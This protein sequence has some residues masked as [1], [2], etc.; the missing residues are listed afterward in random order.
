[1]RMIE[2]KPTTSPSLA[3]LMQ[4]RVS[5]RDV[6]RTG[7]T[8]GV[9][10]LGSSMLG[11]LSS[12]VPLRT[13]SAPELSFTEIEKSV[14]VTHHIAKGYH[15]TALLRWG[16][17]LFSSE[18]T[19]NPT[20]LTPQSQEK[21]IGQNC[22]YTAFMPLP[23]GSSSSTHG[24]L[25][26]NHEYTLSYLMFPPKKKLTQQELLQRVRIEQAAQ[27]FSTVEIK[28]D[29]HG[30]WH[31]IQDSRYNRRVT[32][33]SIVKF[34]G[35][36]AEHPRLHSISCENGC[37][38][39]G[40]F[41][42]CAG[43]VT[44]WGSILTCEENID[45]YFTG[46]KPSN[47]EYHNHKR[48]RIDTNVEYDWH[49][50]D[51][52]FDVSLHP[53]EP[54]HFGWVV[55]YD[56]YNPDSI[57]TKRTAL[58][59][60]KHEGATT[61]L[62]PD[63]RVVVYMGDDEVFQY[64][65]RYVSKDCYQHN[66]EAHNDR[67]LDEGTLYVARFYNDGSLEWIPLVFGEHGLIPEHGFHSQADI[68]IETRFAADIAGATPLDR[69]E[70]IEI[71]PHTG[72]IYVSLTKNK[73]RKEDSI[74]NVNP[75]APNLYGHIL[76]LI[77]T[78]NSDH[79]ATHFTWDIFLQ[80]GN[81]FQTK[82]AALYHPQTSKN[83]WLTNPDNLAF[84]PHGRLWIGT[85]G[86]PE[87]KH[88]NDGLFATQTTGEYRALTKLFFTAPTGAEIT[89]PCF[90]QD[91]KNLFL[92]VQHPA[93]DPHFDITKPSTRWPDFDVTLPPRSS[94]VVITK[95]DNGVIGS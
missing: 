38:A 87:S 26:I 43:G 36:A 92:S 50:V 89:G 57:P 29:A 54:N 18:G 33:G 48:M 32:A 55:E 7:S 42:N 65:Y 30:S 16:D 31:Y 64:L 62:S 46:L 13:F 67:L 21:R 51:A 84:D 79:A 20:T 17:P 74:D 70:D 8:F 95:D 14:S 93:D 10:V 76:E 24:I 83:G 85:D 69:P 58:G 11:G 41:G 9:A 77:P 94:V 39:R 49:Q 6:M 63:G 34:S 66:N 68:L 19:F 72:H 81:P 80:A 75:R 91:G 23:K 82:D 73:K 22:D 25:H 3:A 5:R 2:E 40:T 1:M 35:P 47:P 60:F 59:R 78:G 52:R 28:K 61:V 90:T 15:A 71:H 27:G 53:Y 88:T 86:M 45:T 12:C 4:M 37:H 44:P 56:P